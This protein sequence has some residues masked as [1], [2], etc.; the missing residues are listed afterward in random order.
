MYRISAMLRLALLALM[1][2]ALARPAGAGTR[3]APARTLAAPARTLAA[4]AANPAAPRASFVVTNSIDDND[5][6]DNFAGDGLCADAFGICSLR[7]AIEE[8]NSLAGPDTITFI[9]SMTIYLDATV[10]ALPPVTEE[11]QIDAKGQ[12]DNTL[13]RPGVILD[14]VDGSMYGLDL[15]AD[16]C[17]IYGLGLRNFIS[18]VSIYSNH[19]AVGGVG[20]GQRNVIGGS[21]NP[22][23]YIANGAHENVVQNNWIGLNLAGTGADANYI[24][25]L[26][27]GGAY[28]NTIGSLTAGGGNVISGNTRTGIEIDGATTSENKIYGNK[29]GPAASGGADV[30][31]GQSGIH[32]NDGAQYT[33]VGSLSNRAAGNTI[34]GNHGGGVTMARSSHTLIANNTIVK[35][36]SDGVRVEYGPNNWLY[37]NEIAFNEG[38]GVEIIGPGDGNTIQGCAIHHNMDKGI[39]LRDGG[40]AELA[41]PVITAASINGAAGTGCA[42]CAVQIFC[43]SE[44]EGEF[45]DANATVNAS[46][47]W[48]YVGTLSGPNVTAIVTDGNANTSEFSAPRAVE[49][50]LY[51]PVARK[52]LTP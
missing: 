20:A 16:H 50:R 4:P 42:G 19:N 18:G 40:N 37:Y 14:G 23:M 25:V 49:I 46:G 7:A 8:A 47:Q 45:Y 44:D 5:A 26:I 1:A 10:G 12:W 35:N 51:M 31:N 13:G 32:L 6:H 21:N 43:D 34:V 2:W 36:G 39:E 11:L 27:S 41:A 28:N 3:T 33:E 48:S 22:G 9:Y 52:A 15:R 38:D 30:G 29:I 24:G 17:A